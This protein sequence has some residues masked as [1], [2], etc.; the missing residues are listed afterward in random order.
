MPSHRRRCDQ[1][2]LGDLWVSFPEG[3]PLE[4]LALARGQSRLIMFSLGQR[5]ASTCSHFVAKASS[6]AVRRNG[7][8]K[9]VT[10]DQW[11]SGA[12]AMTI[13]SARGSGPRQKLREGRMTI[14]RF[15]S[16]CV[17]VLAVA[18]AAVA[19]AQANEVTKWNNIAVNTM[20]AQ[21][22]ITSAPP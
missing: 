6:K 12:A 17:I 20:L 15:V 5:H 10:N 11:S 7:P 9:D 13:V 18:L 21:P 4:D 16:S 19:I 1:E 14:R 2:D 8:A 22:P 3:N